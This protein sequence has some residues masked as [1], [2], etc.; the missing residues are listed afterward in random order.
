MSHSFAFGNSFINKWSRKL[1]FHPEW[2]ECSDPSNNLFHCALNHCKDSASATSNAFCSTRFK[3]FCALLM[4]L[5]PYYLLRLQRRG[6]C[7]HTQTQCHDSHALLNAPNH[8]QQAFQCDNIQAD[9]VCTISSQ[10][11]K[12][13]QSGIHE[14]HLGFYKVKG[15]SSL[16]MDTQYLATLWLKTII[17]GVPSKG[18]SSLR[19]QRWKVSRRRIAEKKCKLKSQ[20]P[21]HQTSTLVASCKL[22]Q[23]F[24][25]RFSGASSAKSAQQWGPEGAL[26]YTPG[27]PAGRSW[28]SHSLQAYKM[29]PPV[30]GIYTLTHSHA[31]PNLPSVVCPAEGFEPSWSDGSVFCEMPVSSQDKWVPVKVTT[32]LVNQQ[33]Y[34]RI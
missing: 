12:R 28:Y 16:P 15:C 13:R 29:S 14:T 4:H 32:A 21:R 3:H 1:P 23:T 24:L 10:R 27:Q 9:V 6:V 26:P 20:T 30:N 11:E 34:S 31:K 18:R 17:W 19:V 22:T 2:L 25:Q 8:R 7:V 33:N 5:H